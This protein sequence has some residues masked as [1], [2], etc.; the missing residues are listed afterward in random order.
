MHPKAHCQLELVICF[1][2]TIAMRSYLIAAQPCGMAQ[3]CFLQRSPYPLA[4]VR[5]RYAKRQHFCF[6]QDDPCKGYRLVIFVDSDD[7]GDEAQKPSEPIA[8]PGYEHVR[9]QM[10]IGTKVGPLRLS[11]AFDEL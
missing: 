10:P 7:L 3:R 9:A 11:F 2:A 1:V 5:L 4:T 8:L 6:G